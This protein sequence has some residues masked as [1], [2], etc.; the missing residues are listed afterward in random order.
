MTVSTVYS[1]N[2]Y[3]GNGSTTVFNTSFEFNS[4]TTNIKVSLK[5]TSTGVITVQTL[6]VDYTIASTGVVTML[7]APTSSQKVII[8]LDPDFLQSTDLAENE[9]F[10]QDAVESELDQLKLEVQLLKE[11]VARCLKYDPDTAQGVDATILETSLTAEQVVTVN[12]GA[13]GF[14]MD[15]N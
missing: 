6:G 9:D 12:S 10:P 4:D 3:T 1:P 14:D 8:E 11:Q 7:T 5:N 15:A 2:I 13:N